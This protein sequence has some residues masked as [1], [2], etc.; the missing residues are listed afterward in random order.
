MI[1]CPRCEL[2]DGDFEVQG[3]VDAWATAS[4][5]AVE[6]A[7]CSQSRGCSGQ[8]GEETEIQDDLP[9]S[10]GLFIGSKEE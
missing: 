8:D 6:M 3:L 7:G 9:L 2:V 1:S 4:G 5:A 10:G